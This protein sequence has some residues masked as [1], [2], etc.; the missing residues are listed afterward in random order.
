[1]NAFARE[2][3]MRDIQNP[4]FEYQHLFKAFLK[5]WSYVF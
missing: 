4:V 5:K 3:R 1:M 2:R